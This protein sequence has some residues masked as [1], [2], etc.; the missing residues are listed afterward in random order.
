[1]NKLENRQQLFMHFFFYSRLVHCDH[2]IAIT[3]S[4]IEIWIIC[5]SRVHK[6]YD[7]W[8]FS[9]C[10]KKSEIYAGHDRDGK[11]TTVAATTASE[12]KRQ[13]HSDST[14]SSLWVEFRNHFA[15]SYSSFISRALSFSFDR[16]RCFFI[17]HFILFSLAFWGKFIFLRFSAIRLHFTVRQDVEEKKKTTLVRARSRSRVSD[18]IPLI[19]FEKTKLAFVCRLWIEL[20]KIKIKKKKK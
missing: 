20:Y 13:F 3:L 1:M 14:T 6:Y 11:E 5:V 18:Y 10:N 7:K 8:T 4:C 16:C 9:G 17:V 15:T 12:L 2:S 19:R